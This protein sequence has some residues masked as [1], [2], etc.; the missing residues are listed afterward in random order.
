MVA[1]VALFTNPPSKWSIW[2]W[3]CRWRKKRRRLR[4]QRPRYAAGVHPVDLIPPPPL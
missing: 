1:T 3:L 2:G 4:S